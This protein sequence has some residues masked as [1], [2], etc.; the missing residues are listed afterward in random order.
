[1]QPQPRDRSVRLKVF[2][3]AAFLCGV[4]FASLGLLQAAAAI[5]GLLPVEADGATLLTGIGAYFLIGALFAIVGIGSLR[6]RKWALPL[7]QTLAWTWLL[8]GL[9]TLVLLPSM[10]DG[11]L[12]L[13]PADAA[14]APDVQAVVKLA[15]WMAIL[16]GGLLIPGCFV[17]AYRGPDVQWT[18]EQRD[19]DPSWTD[20]CPSPVLGLSIALGACGIVALP[21]ALRPAVPLFG[22]IWSGPGA[23]MLTLL[24]A[25]S[26]LW[27]AWKLFRLRPSG[28]WGTTLLLTLIGIS[29]GWTLWWGDTNQLLRAAGYP[30]QFV[31]PRSFSRL[32]ALLS[33]AITVATWSYLLRL[34]PYFK[35]TTDQKPATQTPSR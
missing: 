24:G 30:E 23:A 12:A 13:S 31:P 19:R 10:L 26:C 2:G 33:I 14:S 29:T 21:T 17:W 8:A 11:L 5:F 16:I 27:F 32:A 34:R 28:W 6:C 35:P 4:G 22:R 18:F 7:M 9:S 3:G 1:M 15:A 20:R 25:A